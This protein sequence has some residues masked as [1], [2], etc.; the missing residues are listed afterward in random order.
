MSEGHRG[1]RQ[2]ILQRQEE[3]RRSWCRKHH[4]FSRKIYIGEEKLN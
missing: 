3:A 2:V 4:E 1:V